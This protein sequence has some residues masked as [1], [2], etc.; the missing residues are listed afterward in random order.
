MRPVD[1][2]SLPEH[3]Q[4]GMQL[5]V[6]RGIEPGSFLAAVLRNDLMGALGKADSVNINR[7]KDYGMFLYNEVPSDCFGSHAKYVAWMER[8]GMMGH[9]KS[10]A[11]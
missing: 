6:E 4:D 5:W 11:A 8:G 2:S 1:Y 10:E 9:S 3:M 7:L